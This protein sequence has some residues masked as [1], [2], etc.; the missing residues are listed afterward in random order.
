MTDL[1]DFDKLSD[2]TAEPLRYYQKNA[3]AFAAST[4]DV[5]F[6]E[7]QNRFLKYMMPGSLIL[8]FGC[9]SGRDSKHFLDLG[10]SVE[11]VDG[12]PEMCSIAAAFTGLPVR[13]LLFQD[14]DEKEKY[15]GIWACSSILHL[16]GKDLADVFSKT[17]R[18]LKD[19]GVMYT[20]FKRGTFEGIRNGR[21]FT[22]MT[23][24]SLKDFIEET[25]VFTI[26]ELWVSADVRPGREEEKWVNV[27]LEK[28]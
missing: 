11:A 22:D 17:A 15:D 5:D 23:E 13:C 16:T 21:Q 7:T 4:G 6:S 8:D 2:E 24:G 28:K 12:S 10:Y 1:T 25:N 18:A 19:G 27:I 3:A 14:L 20:S 9:G 26:R